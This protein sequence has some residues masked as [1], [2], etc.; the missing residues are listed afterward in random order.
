VP[1]LIEH[2]VMLERHEPRQFLPR[3]SEKPAHVV[4]EVGAVGEWRA[5]LAAEE[6]GDVGLRHVEGVG[7]IAL[8]ETELFQALADDESEIHR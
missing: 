1:L 2:V 4:V 8:I 3:Q 5:L 7:Q 6:L